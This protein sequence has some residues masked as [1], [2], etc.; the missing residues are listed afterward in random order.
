MPN[1]V[2]MNGRNEWIK[3]AM[4]GVLGGGAGMGGS[5]V[6]SSNSPIPER[7]FIEMKLELR[8]LTASVNLQFEKLRQDVNN[9]AL[10]AP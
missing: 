9:L 2:A 7:E 4:V 8:A 6:F 1:H 5:K 10:R 3:W